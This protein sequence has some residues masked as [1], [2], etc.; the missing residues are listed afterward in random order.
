MVGTYTSNL[1]NH[2]QT[3]CAPSQETPSEDKANSQQGKSPNQQLPL[4]ED[5][6]AS[7]V[8]A[9]L[10]TTLQDAPLLDKLVAN[11]HAGQTGHQLENLT[12]N[13]LDVTESY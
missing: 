6:Q 4:P 9:T 8:L 5:A 10:P 1:S 13:S 3:Q 2:G 7:L 11:N 12:H